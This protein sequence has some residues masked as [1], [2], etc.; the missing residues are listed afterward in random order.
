MPEFLYDGSR[1]KQDYNILSSNKIIL[2]NKIQ[3]CA[4]IKVQTIKNHAKKRGF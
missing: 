2:K 4:D 1:K 3:Y